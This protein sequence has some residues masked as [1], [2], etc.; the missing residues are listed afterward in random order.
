MAGTGAAELIKN[1]FHAEFIQDTAILPGIVSR[2]KQMIP[3][4]L[5]AM[6]QEE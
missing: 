5:N 6:K 4:L 1:T 2:K 3:R